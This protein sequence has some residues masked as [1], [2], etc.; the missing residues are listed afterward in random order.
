M[1][2]AFILFALSALMPVLGRV[3]K[4]SEL[5]LSF[6]SVLFCCGALAAGVLS[7]GDL[8]AVGTGAAFVLLMTLCMRERREKR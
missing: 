8:T 6:F 4:R 1:K 3:M 5:L 7:G 2:L